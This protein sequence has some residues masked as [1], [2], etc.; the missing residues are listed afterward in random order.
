MKFTELLKSVIALLLLVGV[1]ISANAQDSS[2]WEFSDKSALTYNGTVINSKT[3]IDFIKSIFSEPNS[4]K[5][6]PN[7]DILYKYESLG[8]SISTNSKNKV[9]FIGFNYAWDGDKRFPE[10]SFKGLL[11]VGNYR[12]TKEST[13]KD[14]ES[15][16]GVKFKCP[17]PL[18]CASEESNS[19]INTLV[20]FQNGTITQIGFM[21]E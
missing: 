6:Y 19:K 17:I 8:I 12:V 13:A 2:Q 4:E 1:S 10:T 7:G 18:M 16:E 3:N 20:G 14:F 9:N 11:K 15:V 5:I 21:L